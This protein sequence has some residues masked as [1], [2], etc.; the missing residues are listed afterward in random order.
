MGRVPGVRRANI[1]IYAVTDVS[2]RASLHGA[3][4]P[5]PPMRALDHRPRWTRAAKG[6]RLETIRGGGFDIGPRTVLQHLF[7]YSG[8]KEKAEPIRRW[9]VYGA[10]PSPRPRI[11]LLFLSPSLPSHPPLFMSFD[12]SS[13]PAVTACLQARETRTCIFTF[14]T[15][16]EQPRFKPF[17]ATRSIPPRSERIIYENTCYNLLLDRTRLIPV[18]E[19]KNGQCQCWLFRKFATDRICFCEISDDK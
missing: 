8:T 12:R 13:C 18:G 11:S 3:K 19:F 7:L 2:T 6:P 16:C 1:T 17:H 5:I 9:C 15:R 14:R 10:L 4:I